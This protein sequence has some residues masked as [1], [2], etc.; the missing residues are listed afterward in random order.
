MIM[1]SCTLLLC[2]HKKQE[3][4]VEEPVEP[5]EPPVEEPYIMPCGCGDE[6]PP[7]TL[8]C[9]G[10]LA[11]DYP[12][13]P[14]TEEGELT[15][16][17]KHLTRQ[18]RINICQIPADVLSSLSTEEL[19][20]VCMQYPRLLECTAL[21]PPD[22]GLD[23]LFKNFNGVRELFQRDDSFMG[24]LNWYGCALQNLEAPD[25]TGYSPS[26]VA[27]ATL[28]LSRYQSPD[29]ANIEN[30]VEIVQHLVCGY[31]KMIKYPDLY[32][33]WSLAINC[34]TRAKILITIDEH[35]LEIIPQG[36][37]NLLFTMR[38]LDEPTRCAID[39][40]SCQIIN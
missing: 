31:E 30:Y 4:P 32:S 24:L 2:C 39:E 28:I 21:S 20:D 11:W 6:W 3:P 17:W 40:L 29:V 27:A 18:D 23:S 22:R 35:N 26:I 36:Y 19:T 14:W 9:R 38:Y 25:D 13:K 8:T 12:V 16:E 34:F 1:L 10:E 33:G 5:V 7:E 15:E 37:S